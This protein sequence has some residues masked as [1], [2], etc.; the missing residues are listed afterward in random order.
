MTTLTVLDLVHKLEQIEVRLL[1]DSPDFKYKSEDKEYPYFVPTDQ[2]SK[3]TGFTFTAGRQN[4]NIGAVTNGTVYL[5]QNIFTDQVPSNTF[6][7][8]N[9]IKDG[10]LNMDKLPLLIHK[11]DF[12]KV[13][14]F[15]NTSGEFNDDLLVVVFDL[16][17]LE[18]FEKEPVD[19]DNLVDLVTLNEKFKADLKVL[20]FKLKELKEQT[21][22]LE[23]SE[24]E[25]FLQTQGIKDNFFSKT[26][27][28]KGLEYKFNQVEFKI[29]GLSSLPSLA[30]VEKKISESKKLNLAD[31]LIS[32]AMDRYKESDYKALKHCHKAISHNRKDLEKQIAQHVFGILD[33]SFEPV[34]IDY[35]SDE[36]LFPITIQVTEKTIKT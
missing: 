30:A 11:D 7:H 16:T 1:T 6:R 10:G 22:V 27:P 3:V 32:K 12:D 5:D 9:I 15:P 18:L 33:D 34:S 21:E 14:E 31:Q 36:F 28:D 29:K 35:Q 23:L 17:K 13:L 20:N 24:E 25:K 26:F 2:G 8:Y 19:I 4:I